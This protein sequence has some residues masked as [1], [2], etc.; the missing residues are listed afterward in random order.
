MEIK[1]GFELELKIPMNCKMG[2]KGYQTGK[3]IS[4]LQDFEEEVI[5]RVKNSIQSLKEDLKHIGKL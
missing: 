3:T 2:S 1:K 5:A 4:T